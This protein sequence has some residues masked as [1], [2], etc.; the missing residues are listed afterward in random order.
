MST[1]RLPIGARGPVSNSPRAP[2]PD[3]PAEAVS[4]PDP[5]PAPAPAPAA[6]PPAAP[7]PEAQVDDYDSLSQGERWERRL[8]ESDIDR[9]QAL[10]I[11]D[12]IFD[13]GYYEEYVYVRGRRAVFRTRKH[14][15]DLRLQTQMELRRPQLQVSQ[16]ELIT[17]YN[18]AASL[19]EW[20][21]KALPHETDADF[22]KVLALIEDLPGP[23][24]SLLTQ[25]LVKFDSKMFLIFSE[26]APENF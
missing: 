7:A 4:T 5:A 19:Y 12:A 14:R 10:G 26:G 21:G 23:L 25:A 22:D 15:D 18:L 6:P 17:R 20:D 16:D 8:K 2:V 9:A 3:D 13:K 24:F 11:I 1:P